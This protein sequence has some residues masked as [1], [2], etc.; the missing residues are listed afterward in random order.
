MN[1]NQRPPVSV[2]IAMISIIMAL[3]GFIML[4]GDQTDDFTLMFVGLIGMAVSLPVVY[5]QSKKIQK[6]NLRIQQE[7]AAKELRTAFY[8]KCKKYNITSIK[9]A[10]DKKKAAAIAESLNC[11]PEVMKDLSGY[12]ES[13]KREKQE[14]SDAAHQAVVNDEKQKERE[15]HAKL[16][17]YAGYIGKD[18]RIAMLEARRTEYLQ[19]AAKFGKL[20]KYG[21]SLGNQKEID[22]AVRGGI[23]SGLAGGAAGVAA[24]MD[25]QAKNAQIRA[26]NAATRQAMAPVV[27][28]FWNK[29]RENERAAEQMGKYIEQ[30]KTKIINKTPK[31]E[32]LKKMGFTDAKVTVSS[33]GAISI[34]VKASAQKP[35][36]ILDAV[37]GT[38]DGTVLANFYEGSRLAGTAELVL[39]LWG[40]GK[41]GEE[42]EGIC[43]KGG[44]KGTAYRVEYTAKHL[45]EMEK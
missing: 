27:T 11:P 33:T 9:T 6:E 30:T 3:V 17:K 26:N 45:W 21:A 4:A 24:A 18:K 22:W 37:E 41:S 35:V 28:G 31:E 2:I 13:I 1:N 42:L 7:A 40:V 23:A 43:L 12:L 14:K 10:D 44:K 34:K 19:E 20:S 39:P 16:T 38:I 25:A 32:V 36:L 29:Q 15:L 5:F 8:D